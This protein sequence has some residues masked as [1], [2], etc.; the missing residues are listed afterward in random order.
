MIAAYARAW[1]SG[2]IAA[3]VE[4]YDDNVVTHYGGSSAF[5]GVHTGKQRFLEVLIETASR[6]QRELVSVDQVHDD[7]KTGAIFAT[8]SFIVDG[9][10]VEV[11][12]ALRYRCDG[13]RIV[14]CW[15][16]D[17]DQ[18]LVDRAWSTETSA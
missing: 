2:D 7:G 10:R 14:E 17:Q 8:E 18:M 13:E 3:M 15:L 4:L 9:E 11:K 6:G 16:F 5:A 1:E 12:R